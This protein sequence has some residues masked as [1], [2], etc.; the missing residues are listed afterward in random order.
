MRCSKNSVDSP[1]RPEREPMSKGPSG[2]GSLVRS[3]AVVVAAFTLTRCF[4]HWVR[5]APA[6]SAGP[7]S[8]PVGKG[9]EPPVG[10]AIF[11]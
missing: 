5:S 10:G 6:P 1:A 3:A 7:V 2:G 9:N 11:E 4:T 8:E